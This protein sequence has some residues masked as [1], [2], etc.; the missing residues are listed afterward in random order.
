[1]RVPLMRL[2]KEKFKKRYIEIEVL[3]ELI[4]KEK[5]INLE[6][7][8]KN[9]VVSSKRVNTETRETNVCLNLKIEEE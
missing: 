1:M 8:A 2:K 3:N 5:Q 4:E 7:L 9:K 6:K